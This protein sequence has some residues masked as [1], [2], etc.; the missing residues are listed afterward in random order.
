MTQF[1]HIP[2]LETDRLILRAPAVADFESYGPLLMSSRAR[3]VGGPFD[4]AGAWKDFCMDVA[5]WLLHGHGALAVTDRVSG[6][7]HGL[8]ALTTRPDFPERELGWIFVQAAEGRG[9][10]F[11]AASAMRDF[12]FGGNGW[13][14]LVSYIDPANT[15]SIALAERLGAELDRNAPRPDPDDLV[16]RHSKMPV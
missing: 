9:I 6:A 11:E 10:A 15:R 12:A 3:F 16:Y 2:V 14:T 8:V 1:L 7:F 5:G 4:L 13:A